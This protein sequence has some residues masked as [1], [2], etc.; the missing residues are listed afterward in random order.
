MGVEHEETGREWDCGARGGRP[1][2]A[3]RREEEDKDAEDEGAGAGGGGREGKMAPT[4]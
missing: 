2:G 3:R 4:R 1:G